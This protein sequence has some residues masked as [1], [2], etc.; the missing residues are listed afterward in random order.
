MRSCPL[1]TATLLL[2]LACVRALGCS[3]IQI[4]ARAHMSISCPTHPNNVA[5]PA[6]NIPANP[7][8]VYAKQGWQTFGHWLGTGSVAKR[9]RP[10]AA[11]HPPPP[12]QN[13]LLKNTTQDG[14]GSSTGTEISTLECDKGSS[15]ERPLQAV[16]ASVGGMGAAVVLPVEASSSSGQHSAKRLRK[17]ATPV[18]KAPLD[19]V[20]P[21]G[22]DNV[23][24]LPSSADG[25]TATGATA[26]G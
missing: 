11:P 15:Q 10:T 4:L 9:K 14:A 19:T 5:T 1:W 22:Q 2:L 20:A 26:N 24:G 7:N 23:A 3:A 12:P 17:A 13:S 16:A 25:N 21:P 18:R 8:K 6:G